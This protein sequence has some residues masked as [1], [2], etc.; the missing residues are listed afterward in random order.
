MTTKTK[1]EKALDWWNGMGLEEQFY[2]TI[3]F[4]EYIVGDR[5]RHPHTLTGSEIELL[6]NK[7][8]ESLEYVVLYDSINDSM[9]E[10]SISDVLEEIDRIKSDGIALGD[11]DYGDS[12]RED[13]WLDGWFKYVHGNDT[14]LWLLD[15]DGNPLNDLS[16]YINSDYD[17][18]Q[19]GK[20]SK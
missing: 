10:W 7:K 13:N 14:F 18:K 6:W 3:E 15:K 9:V 1:R 19:Y 11:E 2:V 17:Q 5:T 12:Y 8:G 4:N 16:Y 20:Y